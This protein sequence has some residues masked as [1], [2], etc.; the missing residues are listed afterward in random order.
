MIR[1]KIGLIFG[2]SSIV[3]MVTALCFHGAYIN[4]LSAKLY[5]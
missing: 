5:N 2:E 4:S 3:A 1:E